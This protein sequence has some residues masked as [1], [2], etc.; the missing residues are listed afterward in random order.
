MAS[1]LELLKFMRITFDDD[2][3]EL[4][5]NFYGGSNSDR[6]SS[7]DGFEEIGKFQHILPSDVCISAL[8]KYLNL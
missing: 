2:S 4:D 5:E 6:F 7:D 3:E 1:R 8:N